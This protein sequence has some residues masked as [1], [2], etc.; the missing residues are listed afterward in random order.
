MLCFSIDSAAFGLT[1]G[2]SNRDVIVFIYDD[3]TLNSMTIETGNKIGGVA[4]LNAGDISLGT[5]FDKDSKKKGRNTKA[6]SFNRGVFMSLGVDFGGV[7]P[8]WSVNEKFYGKDLTPKQILHS[9]DIT[10]PEGTETTTSITEVYRKLGLLIEGKAVDAGGKAGAEEP[11]TP[12]ESSEEGAALATS[13]STA[14]SGTPN[15]SSE[16]GAALATS[17]STAGS[18][19]PNESLEGGTDGTPKNSAIEAAPVAEEGGAL[20]PNQGEYC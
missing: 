9:D 13:A 3:K 14:G 12:N 18:G 7:A 6:F 1:L 11:K 10:M 20:E 15:E 19:T 16:E 17:A 8:Q 4:Q 5:D 2:Y